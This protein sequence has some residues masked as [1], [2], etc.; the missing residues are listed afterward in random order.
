MSSTD[1]LFPRSQEPLPWDWPADPAVS[2]DAPAPLPSAPPAEEG[3]P[4]ALPRPRRPHPG[5][6]VGLLWCLLFLL[7]TQVL[8]VFTVLPVLLAAQVLRTPNPRAA[9]QELKQPEAAQDALQN[10]LAPLMLVVEG[11]VVV[12]SLV[13]IRLVM[14]RDWKRMVALRAPNPAHV[15]FAVLALPAL[16]IL[17]E[18]SFVLTKRWLPGLGDLG[19]PGMEEMVK[20]FQGWPTSFAV[21]V[22]GVGPGVG[23][24]LWCRAFLGRGQ[25][26]RYGLVL[27]VLFT[28]FFFGLIHVDPQQGTMAMLMGIALHYVYLTTRSLWVPILLHFGNN[29]MAMVTPRVPGLEVLNDAPARAAYLVYPAAALLLAA[30]AWA[31]YQSRARLVAADGGGPPPWRPEYPGVELPPPGSGTVVAHHWP[32]WFVWALLFAA[33]ELFVVVLAHAV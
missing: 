12:F 32:R 6:W 1:P 25:V 2:A 31:L 14:G 28:S 33:W 24:E 11:T 20:V 23:E 19:M 7:V 29:S 5:F 3:L 13:V 21:L 18:G 15:L 4:P 16:I 27:G 22:I 30:V 10:L 26:G 9:L 8:P 17:A